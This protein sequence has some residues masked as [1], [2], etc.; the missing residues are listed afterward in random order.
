MDDPHATPTA[1]S[2]IQT[3]DCGRNSLKR[4]LCTRLAVV[5]SQAYKPLMSE[6]VRRFAPATTR[7]RDP[8]LQVLKSLLPQT[9]TILE[10]ASG[11]GEHA[12]YF[13]PAF[14][15]AIWQPT[16]IDEGAIASIN[17]HR[18]A[19]GPA[20][21][22]SPL[23]LNVME[24]EWPI[25]AADAALCVNM[26]HIAPWACCENLLQGCAHV[27]SPGAPLVLYGPFKRDGAHTAPSNAQFDQTLRGQN[28]E[29]GIRDIDEI[30]KAGK[31]RGFTIE[32]P[33]AMPSNNFCLVLRQTNT[34]PSS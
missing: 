23:Y 26:L 21:L 7:N 33:I 1:Y 31:A 6:D 11:T 8:L 25:S 13:A 22:A 3:S 18:Q 4:E 14:G 9:G 34:A 30:A 24:P 27:L 19:D 32:D 17:A 16:D 2:Q 29:W 28:T 10:I 15:N 12:C 5:G 20:N